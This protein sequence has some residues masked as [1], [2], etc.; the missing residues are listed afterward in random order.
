MLDLTT[1]VLTWPSLEH[2]LPCSPSQL[3]WKMSVRDATSR[4]V[5][6]A[7]WNGLG[8]PQIGRVEEATLATSGEL[9]HCL[10]RR[11]SGRE[12]CP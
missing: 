6:V 8:L 4:M 9:S 1:R 11:E 3:G 7:E 12:G 10:T 5:E 2:G